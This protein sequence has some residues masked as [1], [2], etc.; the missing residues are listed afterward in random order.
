MYE[1]GSNRL[2]YIDNCYM[3][4]PFL[5]EKLQEVLDYLTK[6]NISYIIRVIIKEVYEILY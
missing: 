2:V 1:R 4:H 5:Q 3:Y 6:A